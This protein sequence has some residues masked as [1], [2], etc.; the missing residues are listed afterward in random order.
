MVLRKISWFLF[1]FVFN[2]L[3]LISTNLGLNVSLVMSLPERQSR[4]SRMVSAVA[5]LIKEPLHNWNRIFISSEYLRTMPAVR[6]F[7]AVCDK[8]QL[9]SIGQSSLCS[10]SVCSAA[11]CVL[12]Y[13]SR[14][15]TFVFEAK[16][17]ITVV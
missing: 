2:D 13:N 11:Q 8:K 1:L 3:E 10:W 6:S 7:L 9:I 17:P 12:F 15:I 16:S 14:F 4:K 5:K